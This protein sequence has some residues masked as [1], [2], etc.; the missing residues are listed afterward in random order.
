MSKD[1]DAALR[2]AFG[3][4][5]GPEQDVRIARAPGRIN[6]IGEHTDYN[7][8]PVMPFALKRCVRIAFAPRSDR[9]IV[10]RHTDPSFPP[11]S[12][13]AA[14][15]VPPDPSGSWVNYTKAAVEDLTRFLVEKGIRV[16][17]MNCLVSGD[18]PQAAG[19][20][21]S[22]ALVVATALA[23]LSVNET[24]LDPLSLAERM[25]AAERYVGTRGGGMD[26]AAS[27]CGR[28]GF[29]LK[30]DFFPLRV[31][32]IPFPEDFAVVACHSLV[33]APKSRE[34]KLAYNL[35][36]AECRLGCALLGRRFGRTF[37]RLGDFALKWGVSEC[38]AALEQSLPQKEPVTL[39]EI[40]RL[41]QVGEAD[42]LRDFL[43]PGAKEA[44]RDG[45]K[46]LSRCRHVLTE[47]RRVEEAAS[48][49]AAG[50][51]AR[52]GRLMDEAHQSAAFDYEISTPE[53]DELVSLMRRNGA[54]G[55][56]LTGA[57]FGGFAVGLVE[58]REV[59]ALINKIDQHF[60][61]KRGISRNL[62]ALRFCFEPAAGAAVL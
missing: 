11:A 36:V 40:A 7:G 60:Y 2:K 17:G 35:R 62:E 55:A 61:A 20:S 4:V 6:L 30:I 8:L 28:K 29:V 16:R 9:M 44:V 38:L 27:L 53:L 47:G 10:L 19:L 46:I 26:Q 33:Q 51:I 41:L 3:A 5:F 59:E 56:R 34:V 48:A 14:E 13:Q 42:L 22:S 24:E 25:A 50:D 37:E 1:P 31:A 39:A 15:K 49:L 52:L 32:H 23:F 21:S 54:A 57:G 58:R 18:I 45:L 12:Y 43:P